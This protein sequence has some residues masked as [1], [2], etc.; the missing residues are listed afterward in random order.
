MDFE[1]SFCS[2]CVVLGYTFRVEVDEGGDRR[3][4]FVFGGEGEGVGGFDYFVEISIFQ[5]SN[6]FSFSSG[7]ERGDKKG[8][9]LTSLS[10]TLSYL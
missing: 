6:G 1:L 8:D 5:L 4:E 3:V 9:M 2:R 7:F 10:V